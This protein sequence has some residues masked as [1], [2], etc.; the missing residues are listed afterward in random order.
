MSDRIHQITKHSLQ[1]QQ[2]PLQRQNCMSQHSDVLILAIILRNLKPREVYWI[3]ELLFWFYVY[4]QVDL[5]HFYNKYSSFDIQRAIKIRL[6]VNKTV[7]GRYTLVRSLDS[8][9]K[10]GKGNL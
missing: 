2:H 10:N 9:S 3:L 6:L 5:V 7:Q 1:Q 4:F 8:N